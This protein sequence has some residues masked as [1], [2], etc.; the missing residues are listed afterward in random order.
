MAKKRARKP[1]LLKWREA[2]AKS[3]DCLQHLDD[4]AA[5]G[6]SLLRQCAHLARD[7]RSRARDPVAL[8]FE[9]HNDVHNDAIQRLATRLLHMTWT[10]DDPLD[11][12]TVYAF[13]QFFGLDSADPMHLGFLLAV[14]LDLYRPAGPGHPKGSVKWGRRELIDLALK[15]K[16]VRD[17]CGANISMPQAAE[18]LKKKWPEEF[19]GISSLNTLRTRLPEADRELQRFLQAYGMETLE[20][21][22][23]LRIFAPPSEP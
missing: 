16:A 2:I 20:A 11:A 17:E 4:L 5:G 6:D 15:H 21:L 22:R 8:R 19:K 23:I 9:V 1:R 18:L 13:C 3:D 7:L 12:D 10:K 14:L